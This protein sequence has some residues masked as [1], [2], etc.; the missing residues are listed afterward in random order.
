[1]S[2]G[3]EGTIVDDHQ[4]LPSEVRDNLERYVISKHDEVIRGLRALSLKPD[5]LT[6]FF[7]GGKE[8]F[9]TT[10]ITVINKRDL[11][12]FEPPVEEKV[13]QRLLERNRGTVV[14]TPGGV[15]I[16]FILSGISL[17]K[18][19]GE[20]VLVSP[21]P[22]IFYRFQNREFFRV[23]TPFINP[24]TIS[25]TLQQR[26]ALQVFRVT[27]MSCGGL[28]VDD[29]EHRLEVEIGQNFTPAVITIPNVHSF[30][31]DLEVRNSFE[32]TNKN[33]QAQHQVGF[34]FKNLRAGQESMIQ[35]YVNHLQISALSGD[36][37]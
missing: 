13:L 22:E 11:V 3:E 28:R 2:V 34:A 29:T 9:P 32:I 4:N 30:E 35:N 25:L 21:L 19:Q 6:L 36:H 18:F 31:V 15:K 20:R 16:R 37:K 14:G 8:L 17:A 26:G 10:V 1:M 7:D 5:P 33:G 24:V 27:D 12:V 23:H